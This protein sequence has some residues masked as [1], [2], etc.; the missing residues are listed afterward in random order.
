MPLLSDITNILSLWHP[1][2]HCVT[3]FYG[4]KSLI[5]QVNVITCWG[6]RVSCITHECQYCPWN[7]LA[8]GCP[9]LNK[10]PMSINDRIPK[11]RTTFWRKKKQ[12]EIFTYVSH[13]LYPSPTPDHHP[14][15]P[16][17]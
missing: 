14:H 17:K 9:N 2:F 5:Q 1:A 7:R 11:G 16:P 8:S 13:R 12:L 3:S 10:S 6:N 4:F 15:T